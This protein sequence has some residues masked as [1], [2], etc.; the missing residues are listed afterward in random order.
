M[1]DLRFLDWLNELVEHREDSLS[2][3]QMVPRYERIAFLFCCNGGF[4]V[5]QWGCIGYRG[6]PFRSGLEQGEAM[7]LMYYAAFLDGVAYVVDGAIDALKP[8]IDDYVAR[9]IAA[10]E[11]ARDAA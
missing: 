6:G 5:H 1:T 10:Y 3:S 9:R 11:A 4:Q 7:E 2:E 8:L